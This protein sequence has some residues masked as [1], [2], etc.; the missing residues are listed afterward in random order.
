MDKIMR[1][2]QLH[3]RQVLITDTHSNALVLIILNKIIV[4][5][6]NHIFIRVV[7]LW[8]NIMFSH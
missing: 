6:I 8:T 3:L 1:H 5:P 2:Q 4:K 7:N